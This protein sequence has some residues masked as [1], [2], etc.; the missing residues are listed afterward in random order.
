ME[1]LF[2]G[3]KINTGKFK[4]MRLKFIFLTNIMYLLCSGI[5]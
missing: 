5:M 1:M 4:R 2:L 3:N